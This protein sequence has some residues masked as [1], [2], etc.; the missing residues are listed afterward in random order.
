MGPCEA[1][2]PRT[3]AEGR[4]VV[5]GLPEHRR[6]VGEAMQAAVKVAVNEEKKGETV[7]MK[8]VEVMALARKLEGMWAAAVKAVATRAAVAREARVVM[9]VVAS[10]GK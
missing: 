5:V 4:V 9:P 1:R 3:V 10:V 6:G 8:V 2:E 7:E